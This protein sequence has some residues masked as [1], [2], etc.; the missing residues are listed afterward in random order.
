MMDSTFHPLKIIKNG[1]AHHLVHCLVAESIYVVI[2]ST[3]STNLHF[4]LEFKWKET[5]IS[6]RN[7]Q[8]V[9]GQSH[10]DCNPIFSQ[11]K[12][13]QRRRFRRWATSFGVSEPTIPSLTAFSSRNHSKSVLPLVFG[14]VFGVFKEFVYRRNCSACWNRNTCSVISSQISLYLGCARRDTRLSW[15]NRRTWLLKRWVSY[16]PR[17]SQNFEC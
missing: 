9:F 8:Y 5:W 11:S 7:I 3:I 2:C 17:L 4:I 16:T 1:L 13:V 15:S 10:I 14:G 6:F 12:T